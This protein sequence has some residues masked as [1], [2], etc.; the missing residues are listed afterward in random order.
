MNTYVVIAEPIKKQ[1]PFLQ[2]IPSYI[3]EQ[4]W[5]YIKRQKSK[6]TL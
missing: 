1:I 4:W 2:I 3:I 6:L 5:S